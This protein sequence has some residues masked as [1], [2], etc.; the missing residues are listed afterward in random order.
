M[1]RRTFLALPAAAAAVAAPSSMQLQ[2]R[3][4]RS[5]ESI[6][7]IDTHEHILPE[8]DRLKLQADFFTLASHYAI[9]DVISAGLKT[10]DAALLEKPDVSPAEKWRL[11]EPWWKYARQT[12]YGECLRIAV[13][14][15]YGFEQISLQ[16]L[17][18][19][20][21]AL[22]ARNKPGL[23]REVLKKRGKIRYAINDEYWHQE[24]LPVDPEYFALARKFDWLLTPVTP[25]GVAR[26]EKLAD[27]PLGSIRD[28]KRALEKQFELSLKLGM[29]TVKSTMAY[30]RDLRFDEVNEQDAQREFEQ[31]LKGA[32]PVPEGFRALEARPYRKV[33]A[34]MMHHLCALC[35]EHNVPF[36]FHT[37]LQA[38]NGNFV[39]NTRPSALTNLFFLFPKVRFDLF[40]IGYPYQGETAVLAKEFPNAYVDFCWMHIVSPSAARRALHEMLDMVPANKIFGFGGDYR[41]PELSY[42]HLVMA[43]RNIAAVLA[44][45]VEARI[46]REEEAIELGRWLMLD[47][48]ANIFPR[49]GGTGSATVAR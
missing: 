20:N 34:H 2:T 14:E 19:L 37:G 13:K 41:Y 17:P 21:E 26:L 47:N 16:T 35:S 22:S 46:C 33:T 24:P 3:L 44:E 38:G 40:H 12:G 4:L 18:R 49:R 11:F 25:G 29:V 28:L 45:R 5:L 9:N 48:A 10:E 30:Q 32:Q 6:E 15:I 27:M 23:Y 36:Q 1:R 43:R 42:A 8:P 31:L 39:A 7:T